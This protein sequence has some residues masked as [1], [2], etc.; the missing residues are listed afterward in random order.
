M[1]GIASILTAGSATWRGVSFNG[2]FAGELLPLDSPHGTP[3][4]TRACSIGFVAMGLK[5]G[6]CGNAF[7]KSNVRHATSDAIL[8]LNNALMG[9]IGEVRGSSLVLVH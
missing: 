2:A 3:Q 4:T 1:A 5:K 7:C 8:V 9:V 6:D